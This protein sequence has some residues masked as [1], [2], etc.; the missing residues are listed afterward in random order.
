MNNS[1][2]IDSSSHRRNEDDPY[3]RPLADSGKANDFHLKE[4]VANIWEGRY[5]VLGSVF[6]FL[7]V[8]IFYA[9]TASP[10]YQ[11]EGL[12]QTETQKNFGSQNSEFTKIEGAYSLPT[13]APGEIEILKSN[14]VLGRVVETMVLD[15]V[16]RPVFTPVIGKLL[17]RNPVTRPRIDIESFVVPENMKGIEFELIT[18]PGG[19]FQWKAPD[20][21]ILTEGRPG[22]R[23]SA[24]YQGNPLSLKVRSL[25]GKP[26]QVFSLMVVHTV[27]A[28][29]SLRL[30]LQVEE[31]GKNPNAPSNIL[32]IGLE[33]A[34]PERGAKILNAILNQYIR[35][36]VER[37][38]GESSKALELMEKQRPALQAQLAEA[39]SRLN[40]YRRRSG[41]VDMAREGEL[42]LQQGSSLDAQ[43]SALR[44]KRQ[45]LLRTY[46]ERSDL[47]VTTD[48]QITHLQAE[49]RKVGQKV[50]ALP[51]T[52]QEVV[53]LTRDAQIKSEMY[54]SLLNSIQQLQN[55]L[56]GSVGSARVVDYAI[57][58][59][60]PIFPKKKILMVLFLFLGLVVGSGLTFVHRLLRPGIE[61]H[62]IIEAKLGLP[63][64]VTI[65]HT[66]SQKK[67]ELANGEKA[68][69]LHLLAV[70]D[71]EDMATESLRSLRTVLH[72]TMEKSN[73]RIIL[74]TG[75]SPAIGKSFV[76]ANLGVVIAQAGG[77]VLLVDADMRKGSLHRSFGAKR[78]AGGLSEILTGRTDWKSVIRDTDV[79][80]LSLISTGVLPPDPLML[81]MS[82][83]FSEFTA[84]ISGAFDFI[85]FDAPPL[86]PVSDA[87]VIG[88]QAETIL[89][90]AKYGANPLDE[91]RTCQNRL[92]NLGGRLK[93]CV[94]NDVKLVGI[95][96]IYGYY[97]YDYAYK[98]KKYQA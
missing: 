38:A 57:P 98:Y 63:V 88:S 26:G 79:A 40:E 53:R 62:R 8:G 1:S 59:F 28:I 97:K 52:Q 67:I 11:V 34:D 85:I 43:I 29:N 90:V 71:P 80:G 48:Q 17:T 60:I 41:A 58:N 64:L 18:L 35:Q 47:V 46:T 76:S 12:L 83:R 66:E 42:Y 32:W 23:E 24:V 77:R 10:V 96:G 68:S 13:A 45:E 16:A 51:R 22:D 54:T 86:I 36:A 82:S 94:F 2:P 15:V 78:R 49:A 5:L 19:N 44:Q 61:D 27:N 89:L 72:F 87:I 50:T 39:E 93:G 7:I 20:G 25:N 75:P 37:K 65:P 33:A 74:V 91:L 9:W 3:S 81:L 21:S 4:I 31:R 30:N 56:A 84:A 70:R 6:C 92:K 69:G 55:T 73:N 95:G 14:L